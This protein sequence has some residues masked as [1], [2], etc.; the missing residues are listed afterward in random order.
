MPIMQLHSAEFDDN[1]ILYINTHWVKWFYQH[2]SGVTHVILGDGYS[3]G[4]DSFPV[5]CVPV[6]EAPEQVLTLFAAL[7]EPNA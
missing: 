4:P 2:P 7:E 6:Q 1:R 5:E 3:I